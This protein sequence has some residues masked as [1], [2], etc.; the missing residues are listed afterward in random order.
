MKLEIEMNY[1]LSK[2]N[3]SYQRVPRYKLTSELYRFSMPKTGVVSENL[4]NI[5]VRKMEKTPEN[6]C[7]RK[8]PLLQPKY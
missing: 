2:I 6:Y 4:L 8:F 1:A 7:N 3:Q 5:S